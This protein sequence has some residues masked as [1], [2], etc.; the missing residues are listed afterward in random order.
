MNRPAVGLSAE[1]RGSAL[2]IKGDLRPEPKTRFDTLCP[3]LGEV[4]EWLKAAPC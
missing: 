1:P 3:Q 2:P 4:A